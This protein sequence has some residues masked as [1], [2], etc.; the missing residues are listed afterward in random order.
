MKKEEPMPEV[1]VT[2]DEV[3]PAAAGGGVANL[4]A[5]ILAVAVALIMILLVGAS[6]SNSK[7]FYLKPVSGGLEVWQGKFS[8]LGKERLLFLPGAKAPDKLKE[9]Y[10]K[11]EVYPLV[12]RHY[13]KTADALIAAEKVPDFAR[14]HKILTAAKP[15][16]ITKAA[17]TSLNARMTTLDMM[18]LVYKARVAAD[19]N[20]PQGLSK[21]AG[22]LKKAAALPLDPEQSAFIKARQARV[23]DLAKKARAQKAAAQKTAVKK[24]PVK[25]TPAQTPAAKKTAE[26]AKTAAPAKSAAQK[27]PR[28]AA[29][30]LEKK[31]R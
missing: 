5:K 11:P 9:V 30:E 21:A 31:A 20:T 26:K 2:Y 1:T 28:A 10:A 19:E 23:S 29:I 6:L 12:T 3:K 4:P 16:A 25:K 8:P 13:L 27:A 22:L 15:F 18:Q 7:N 24:P 14:I 17:K